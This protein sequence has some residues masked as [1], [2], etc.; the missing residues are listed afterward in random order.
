MKKKT[1]QETIDAF[2]RI[3]KASKRKPR[4]LWTDEG[5]EFY[6]KETRDFLEKA[7]ITLYSVKTHLKSSLAERYVRRLKT[8]I[9]RYFT[10]TKKHHFLSFLPDIVQN[11]NNSYNRSIG[12]KPNSVSKKNESEAWT[13]L[14]DKVIQGKR[15][16]PRFEV[17]DR[18]RYSQKATVKTLQKKYSQ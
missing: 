2:K 6:A 3:F 1:A 18:V 16:I 11:V 4:K 8:V 17:G 15:K 12:M 9:E 14:Y 7:G 13:N 10:E 5:G